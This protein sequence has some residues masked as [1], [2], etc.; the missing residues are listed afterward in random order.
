M[1]WLALLPMALR[2][3]GIILDKSNA[4]AKSKQSYFDM[5]NALAADDGNSQALRESALSQKQ[6]IM[7][8]SQNGQP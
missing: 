3:L 2:I 1:N 7:E 4:S 8:Q 6:R 5:L